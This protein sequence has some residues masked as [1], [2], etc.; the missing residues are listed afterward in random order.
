M[1][2]ATRQPLWSAARHRRFFWGMGPTRPIR[3]IGPVPKE[4]KP[5]WLAAR[6]NHILTTQTACL[7]LS[8]DRMSWSSRNMARMPQDITDAE[9]D[10]LQVLWEQGPA[11][12]R[13][14][15]D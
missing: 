13:Q 2:G 1:S 15:T 4:K 7:S 14:I 8:S 11:T 6:Q 10:V 3:L 9:L 5:R 12:I